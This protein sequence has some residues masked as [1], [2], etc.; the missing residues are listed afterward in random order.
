MPFQCISKSQQNNPENTQNVLSILTHGF[1]KGLGIAQ[2]KAKPQT[3]CLDPGTEEKI[4]LRG[5]FED[6]LVEQICVKMMGTQLALT[7]DVQKMM[8]VIFFV[9]SEILSADTNS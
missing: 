1:L 6:C 7:D 4:K 8:S 3:L 9:A 5:S 2:C